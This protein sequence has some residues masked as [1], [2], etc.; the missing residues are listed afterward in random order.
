[1]K[2][3][4]QLLIK[5][6]GYGL[7]LALTLVLTACG[8]KKS[9]QSGTSSQT[10]KLAAAAQLNTIDIST[11]SG[12]GQ[13]GNVYESFY[14]L[15]NN[16]KP[17]AGLAKSAKVSA[18][19]QTYTFTLRTA[20]WSNGDPITAHDFVYSWRRT[21]DP[22]TKSEYA[23]LFNGIKNAEAISEG[24]LTPDKLGISAP[25]KKTVVVNLDRPI[26]YF[27]VLMAYPLFAP[28][29]QKVVEKYGK[30]YATNSKYMVYS[31]PFKISGWKGTNNSWKFVK[32]NQYWDAKKV[33]LQTISYKVVSDAQTSLDLYQNNQLDLSKLSQ[34]QVANYENDKEYIQYPYSYVSFLSYN[35]ANTDA[36]KKKLLANRD[37]RLAIS[38]ALDRKQLTK[39]VLGNGSLVPTGFVSTDLA[40]NPKT[41][42]DFSVEQKTTNTMDYNTKL[43][44][45][46]WQAA[47][48]ATG[49]HKITLT[50]LAGN[51]NGDDPSTGIVIQ[52]LKGQL[53][54]V[55]SGLTIKIRA[56]PTQVATSERREGKFDIALAGWGADFNDPISFLTIPETGTD[57]NYG[58]YH[59]SE[60]DA[61]LEKAAK[62]D[63][64][65]VEQRWEDMVQASKLL[66]NDQGITPLYQSVYS[67]MQKSD[68]KGIIHNTAGT[69]WNYKYAYIK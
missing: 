40:K 45:V 31:G 5:K 15:G 3:K 60:Y 55:L 51:D 11:S 9:N 50:I 24:K 6:L 46:K 56:V 39:K 19:G 10:L 28:Q 23:Y 32:N 18:D 29:N 42:Q 33:K 53:E 25:N 44:K 30:K 38:L 26:S 12:Y 61:L 54:K 49:I 69:Q 1:M 37:A 59:N 67:F 7:L 57:Y 14:R 22:A 20:K 64:N 66:S 34:E 16:G 13:T 62:T 36:N 65:N 58:K 17:A 48:K 4:Q 41:G 68:V 52:Y 43:A 2:V 8:A 35:F 21:I 63:A 47:Q 27:K